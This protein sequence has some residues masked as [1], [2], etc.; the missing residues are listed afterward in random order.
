MSSDVIKMKFN[1]VTR[2]SA[3]WCGPCRQ[4]API[5]EEFSK[6]IIDEWNVE[7]VDID[8]SEGKRFAEKHGIR[9]VPATVIERKGEDPL[10]V[11]G[12]LSME[13]LIKLFS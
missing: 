6:S 12:M 4:Y 11:P 1:K 3:E 5:F 8:D 7:T 13:K 10:V 2:V 9:S